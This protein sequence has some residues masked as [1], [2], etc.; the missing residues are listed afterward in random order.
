[1]LGERFPIQC[2]RNYFSRD[3]RQVGMM[4]QVLSTKI[5]HFGKTRLRV[6]RSVFSTKRPRSYPEPGGRPGLPA[7]WRC[8]KRPGKPHYVT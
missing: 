5:Y 4:R 3:L 2:E 7:Q 1:M 6:A 8:L